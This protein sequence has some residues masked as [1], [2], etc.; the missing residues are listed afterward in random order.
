MTSEI[1]ELLYMNG[2][3]FFSSISG[4][5][6]WIVEGPPGYLANA[7]DCKGFTS[8]STTVLGAFWQYNSTGGGM[9]W[10]VNCETQ[11]PLAC[12]SWE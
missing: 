6:S 3:S 5:T 1:I 2:E 7:N 11:K 12:C 4:N 9:G 8:D 10:L